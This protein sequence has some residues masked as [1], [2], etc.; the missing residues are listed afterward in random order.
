M[1]VINTIFKT[2]WGVGRWLRL[3][4]GVFF[5]FDAFYKESGMVALMGMFLVYQASFNTGCGLGSSSCG[6]T[7]T[8]KDVPDLSH[9]YINLNEKK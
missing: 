3:A 6:P 4:I 8:K 2:P 1:N 9:T 5:L 7:I